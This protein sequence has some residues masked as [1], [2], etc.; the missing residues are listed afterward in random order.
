MKFF[1]SVAQGFRS[2]TR[3]SK[4]EFL[5]SGM[6]SLSQSQSQ[7][8]LVVLSRP[9]VNE[10]KLEELLRAPAE[11]IGKGE[12]ASLYKVMLTNGITVVVKRIKDWSISSLHFN[13]RMQLLSQAKHPHVLSPLAFYASKQEKLLVYQYQHNGSLFKLLH[14]KVLLCILLE[15]KDVIL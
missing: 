7:S 15:R 12:K 10:L 2:A 1:E 5:E 8:Q 13:Q 9:E 4:S 6:V 11:L 14:G 3:N